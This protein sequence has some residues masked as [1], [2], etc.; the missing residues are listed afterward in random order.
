M[1]YESLGDV[2]ASWNKEENWR[3]ASEMTKDELDATE[4]GKFLAIL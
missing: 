2:R 4:L 3:I 1:S